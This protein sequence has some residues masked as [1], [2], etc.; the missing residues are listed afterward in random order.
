MLAKDR[1][2]F[3]SFA[4]ACGIV[5]SLPADFHNPQVGFAATLPL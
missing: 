3:V 4:A 2:Q 1:S 5:S